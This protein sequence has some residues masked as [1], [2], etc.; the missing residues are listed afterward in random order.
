MSVET[1]TRWRTL[2]S[3]IVVLLTVASG[4]LRV[5]DLAPS[6][7]WL[8]DAWVAVV[9]RVSYF[10]AVDT[11]VT[12]PGFAFSLKVWFDLVGFSELGSQ[13]PAYVA[14]S[15]AAAAAF[16]VLRGRVHVAIAV[17]AGIAVAFAPIH[18]EQSV[19]VKQYTIEVLLA[20]LIVSCGLRALDEPEKAARLR[21]LAVVSTVAILFSFV[22]LS[23]V[24]SA[25]IVVAVVAARK[26][27]R[28]AVRPLAWL[29]L[30][31]VSSGVLYVSLIRFRLHD[32]LRAFWAPHYIDTGSGIRVGLES[33]LGRL[34]EV[35]EGFSSLPPEA[36]SI[37]VVVALG[38]LLARRVSYFCITVL[39]ILFAI[40][41]AAL[42]RAPLGGGRTDLYLFAPL[43]IGAALGTGV[44][45]DL[46]SERRP[47]AAPRRRAASVFGV[48][49]LVGVTAAQWLSLDVRPYPNEDLRP[50]IEI[51]EEN[52]QPGDVVLLYYIS[53]YGYGLYADGSFEVSPTQS[54]YRLDFDDSRLIVQQNHRVDPTLYLQYAEAA[55]DL[56]GRLWLIGSH[57]AFDW[58]EIVRQVEQDLD[59]NLIGSWIRP[60]AELF[61]YE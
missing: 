32:G 49:V 41:L 28:A 36:T 38:A 2:D 34:H 61:L 29:M 5:G 37:V 33:T 1:A 12:A 22:L 21:D 17:G 43:L 56:G 10:D 15:V 47:L 18:I 20:F 39:P 46:A 7:L 40:I 23:V 50:L 55:D 24:A 35:L 19:H 25:L 4:L 26:D 45:L 13:L 3:A 58:E 60:G 53:Q 6:S 9:H 48:A 42:E 8:D 11:G 14:G 52:R 31:V 27:G 51:L 54:P 57:L 44:L 16:V 59:R 30:P